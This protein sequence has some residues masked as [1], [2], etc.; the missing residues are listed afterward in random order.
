VTDSRFH[1]PFTRGGTEGGIQ[2]GYLQSTGSSLIYSAF[3]PAERLTVL[4][5]KIL[6]LPV[7]VQYVVLDTQIVQYYSTDL[8]VA[9]MLIPTSLQIDRQEQHHSILSTRGFSSLGTSEPSPCVGI[10]I[11]SRRVPGIY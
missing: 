6:L 11:A 1:E 7:L 10:V 5:V 4:G 8:T 9:I 3:V 2:N